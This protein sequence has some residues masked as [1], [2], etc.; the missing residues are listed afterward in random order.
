M[1]Q[2]AT[3]SPWGSNN[4]LQHASHA[5]GHIRLAH[6][7]A[8]AP[9]VARAARI[10][11][12]LKARRARDKFFDSTL[13]ADP[14]W[15][16]LLELYAARLAHRRLSVSAVCGGAGVPA[17]TALRWIR[18]LESLG[19]VVRRE[20]PMDGRRIFLELSENAASQME[21]FFQSLF[22][23]EVII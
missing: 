12:V 16:I 22:A 3:S 10:G 5:R 23:G 17:T 2:S 4:E 6:P 11:Q 14:A 13:F 15:D 9:P 18:T 1:N 8:G 20:D 7:S 21:H 19:H